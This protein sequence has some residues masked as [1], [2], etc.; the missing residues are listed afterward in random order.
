[1]TDFF[2]KETQ[3]ER[4]NREEREAPKIRYLCLATTLAKPIL[5]VLWMMGFMTT[6]GTQLVNRS[7]K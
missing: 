7:T 6:F 2:E 1:M 4:L 3:D 5:I